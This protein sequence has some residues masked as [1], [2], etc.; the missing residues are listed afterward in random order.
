MGDFSL[1]KVELYILIF[2]VL[3]DIILIV[4]GGVLTGVEQTE[5]GVEMHYN[6]QV[7]AFWVIVSVIVLL[8]AYALFYFAYKEIEKQ[9]FKRKIK[10]FCIGCGIVIVFGYFLDVYGT[11]LLDLPPLGSASAAVGMAI[12]SLAFGKH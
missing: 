11:L 8:T 3:V 5:I 9:E 4:C 2:P 6:E 7:F 1:F 12:A 10:I